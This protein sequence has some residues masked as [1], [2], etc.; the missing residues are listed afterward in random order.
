ML[1]SRLLYIGN[2]TKFQSAAK[3]DDWFETI[4]L[5]VDRYWA[6]SDEFPEKLDEYDGIFISGSPYGAYEDI[7]FINREHQLIQT[8]AER[9]IPMLGICFGSQI[10]ASALCGRDQVFKRDFCEIG[11][12]DLFVRGPAKQDEIAGSLGKTVRM[13]VW[14]N[15]EVRDDHPDMTILASSDLCPNQIWRWRDAP[16]WG[17]Q[18]HPEFTRDQALI[19]FEE[20]RSRMELDG[21]NVD[22]LKSAADDAVEAKSMLKAF[23]KVVKARQ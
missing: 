19:W 13:F 21:A 14:H 12:K 22:C 16:V 10:L 11:Y 1:G 15:D 3:L 7:P 20:N 8:A 17:I 4:G 9:N 23:A 6:F 18:G 5:T 2:G